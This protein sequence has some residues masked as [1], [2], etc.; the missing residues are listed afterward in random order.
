MAS[1]PIILWQ[2][3]GEKMETVRDLF[4]WAPKSLWMVTAAMKWKDA[5]SLEENFD[6]PR[7][8]IKKHRHHFA[9]KGLYSQNYMVFSVVMFGCE[10]WTIK[11]IECWRIDAFELWCGRRLLRVPWIAGRSSQSILKEISPKYSITSYMWWTE[12]PG[13]LQFMGSQRVGH[14]W[15]TELNWLQGCK[16][17]SIC[18]N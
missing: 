16:D 7:Q 4:S 17:S 18:A 3:D 11:K 12:K 14:N 10:S 1:S 9:F 6:K 15:A 5:C 13:V 8:H 2:P